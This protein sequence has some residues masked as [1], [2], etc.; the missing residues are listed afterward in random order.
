MT[1]RS[2]AFKLALLV[3]ALGLMQAVVVLIFSYV[4][5]A[6]SLD[7]QK[8]RLLTDTVTEVQQLLDSVP[9]LAAVSASA[10]RIADLLAGREDIY[11]AVADADNGA[12]LIAFSAVAVESLYRL[13]NDTWALDAFLEWRSQGTNQPMLSITST[14]EVRNGDEYVMMISIDRTSDQAL[15]SK[16]LFTALTAAPFALAIVS[17]GALVIVNIGLKPLNRF[18]RAAVSVTTRNLS[19]RIDPDNLPSELLPLCWAFNSML[20]RLDEGI[21]RLSQFSGDLAHEMRTPLATLLGRTQVALSQPRT[22]DQLLDLLEGNVEELERLSRLVSDMLFLAQADNAQTVID[23]EMVDLAAEARKVADYVDFIAQERNVA[24][25]IRG[26][27]NVIGDRGLIQRA[28]TNLF[29]NAIRY[30]NSDHTVAVEVQETPDQVL[31]TVANR[32]IDIPVHDQERLFDRLYRAEPSR[33]REI[34][35]TGLGLAIVK[36]VMTMHGGTTAVESSQGVTQFTLRFPT[37]P[38]PA[39]P[40]PGAT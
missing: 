6:R 36:A 26:H 2:L 24:F 20:D 31:L 19:E 8:R 17:L 23:R 11:L 9:D 10:F 38:T 4:T 39:M 16:F 35:G 25:D 14:G 28:I 12:R 32:G 13:E 18:R 33:S 7:E 27:G 15:L 37:P 22:H 3:G 5:M 21:Q 1:P 40:A 34:G 29:S 30:G